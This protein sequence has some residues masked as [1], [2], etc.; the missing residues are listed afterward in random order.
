MAKVRNKKY[1]PRDIKVPMMGNSRNNLA[2]ELRLAV[3]TL[4]EAPTPEAFNQ[5]SRMLA[6]LAL[7]GARIEVFRLVVIGMSKALQKVADRHVRVG[8]VGV[9]AGEYSKSRFCTSSA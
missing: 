5:L 8:K 7:A 3:M 2:L 4:V 1:R 9:S 6:S